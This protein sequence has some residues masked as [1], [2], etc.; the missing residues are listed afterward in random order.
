V[1]STIE[2]TAPARRQ[3]RPDGAP[4]SAESPVEPLTRLRA[5]IDFLRQRLWRNALIVLGTG[6]AGAGLSLLLPPEYTADASFFPAQQS[7][8]SGALASAMGGLTMLVG[9][10]GAGNTGGQTPQFFMD[11]FKSRAFQDSMAIS[12][13]VVDSLGTKKTVENFLIKKAKNAA[14]KREKARKAIKGALRADQTIGGIVQ[15]K[16]ITESPQASAAM[17]NRAIQLIDQQNVDFR[18]REALQRRVFNQEFLNEVRARL[19]TSEG[20]LENFLQANRTFETSPILKERYTSLY[21]EVSRIR[22]LEGSVEGQVEDERL[23]EYNDAAV[24]TQVDGAAIPTAKS[25]P[26][27]K[28]ITAGFLMLAA[29]GV[30]W[31]AYWRVGPRR[32]E[33]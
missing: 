19:D 15:I 23:N 33:T 21:T 17:A 4:P 26:P 22:V 13:I 24:V 10:L 16:V 3:S 29:L 27:K 7:S 11:L 8:G 32:R 14:V 9:A 12:T 25:G 30:F 18:H 31:R 6:V 20:R 2:P 5:T 1:T 28:L